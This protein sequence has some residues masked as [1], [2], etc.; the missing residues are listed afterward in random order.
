MDRTCGECKWHESGY[1][2]GEC[3]RPFPYWANVSNLEAG[4]WIRPDD[5]HA[6]ECPCF[7]REEGD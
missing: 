2:S 3:M 6:E 7:E 1:V 4:E 5:D